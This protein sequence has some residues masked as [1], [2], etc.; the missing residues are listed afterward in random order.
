MVAADRERFAKL[1]VMLGEVYG[2][3]SLLKQQAYWMALNQYEWADVEFAVL[4]CLRTRQSSGGYPGSW[5]TPGDLIALMWNDLD[6]ASDVVSTTGH[7]ALPEPLPD[8]DIAR[9][10]LA[11]IDEMLRKL[12]D[13]LPRMPQVR[14]DREGKEVVQD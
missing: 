8:P 7:K 13:R 5:P 2:E 6:T 3:C 4:R 1:M 10:Y 11:E 9:K 12:S 14:V